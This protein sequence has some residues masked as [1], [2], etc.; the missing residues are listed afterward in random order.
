MD[1]LEQHSVEN[2][3]FLSLLEQQRIYSDL[4]IM[5]VNSFA[6][7]CVPQ[8]TR[9]PARSPAVP[10]QAVSGRTHLPPL[11]AQRLPPEPGIHVRTTAACFTESEHGSGIHAAN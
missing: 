2:V 7:I 4:N 5:Q 10:G 1:W 8:P 9:D 11:C 6:A 3:K